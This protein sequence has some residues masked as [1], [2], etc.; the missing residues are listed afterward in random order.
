MN[1]YTFIITTMVAVG[2]CIKKARQ[3]ITD[4]NIIGEAII[5]QAENLQRRLSAFEIHHIQLI[6]FL[7]ERGIYEQ[8]NQ[9]EKKKL[10]G[11]V[12]CHIAYG[13]TDCTNSS[14]SSQSHF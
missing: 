6:F 4:S 8:G 7:S 14:I 12:C 2:I 3:F 1:R 9:K 5:V 13:N 11:S 10:L